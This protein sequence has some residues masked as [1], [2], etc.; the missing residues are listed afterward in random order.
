MYFLKLYN[1]ISFT[2]D[3]SYQC[4]ECHV[5]YDEDEESVHSAPAGTSLQGATVCRP[6]MAL[7][8]KAHL[9]SAPGVS[10]PRRQ[11]PCQLISTGSQ[12]CRPP[13]S[14]APASSSLQGARGCRPQTAVP[15]P[16]HLFREPEGVA[17]SRH[18]LCQL[19]SSGSQRVSLQD[20]TAPASSSLQ[21]ARG[22]APRRQ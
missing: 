8:L 17:P 5:R 16:A 20:G 19:I 18:C 7:P 15:L 22:V 2:A 4:R 3:R 12:R 1:Y 6:Q 10:L 14:S 13:D 9:F 21:G 11:C